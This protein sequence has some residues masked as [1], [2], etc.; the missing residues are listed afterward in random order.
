M[1]V[2]T[3]VDKP[4]FNHPQEFE[5]AT[6]SLRRRIVTQRRGQPSLSRQNHCFLSRDINMLAESTGLSFGQRN[7]R[8]ASSF[9][10]RVDPY[11][12]G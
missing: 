10:A 2:G 8:C 3:L 6:S 9:G 7:E 4:E 1:T 5:P 11:L 12:R